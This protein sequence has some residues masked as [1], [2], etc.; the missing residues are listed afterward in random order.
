MSAR[1]RLR[2]TPRGRGN[3]C[4]HN[5][6]AWRVELARPTRRQ[7]KICTLAAEVF[8][9]ALFNQ[10]TKFPELR[11]C[12]RNAQIRLFGKPRRVQSER[13][14]ELLEVISLV[15]RALLVRMDVL[16]LRVGWH[17]RRIRRAH[18]RDFQGMPIATIAR[19]VRRDESSVKRALTILR[20]LGWVPGPG[21]LGPWIIPQPVER[22][23]ADS[24]HH[25]GVGCYKAFPA[26]RRISVA[27]FQMLGLTGQLEEA[28]TYAAEKPLRDRA[29]RLADVVELR[30][31]SPDGRP[32]T[33]SLVSA[34][35]AK[36]AY[37]PPDD[38]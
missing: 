12:L 9:G 6:R 25:H 32:A 19:W 10:R 18:Q 27:W 28:Q 21:R 22:E 20:W 16:S 8:H 4:D 3:R 2:D 1:R 37:K 17:N 23:C 30:P 11:R 5:P 31:R 7:P 15:M 36:V 38:S 34:L 13:R 26:V 29:A 14:S 24:A 35:A 33:I